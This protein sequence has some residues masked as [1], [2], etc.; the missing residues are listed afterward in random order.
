MI[1]DQ[2]LGVGLRQPLGL[3]A[4]SDSGREK[5]LRSPPTPQQRRAKQYAANGQRDR[6]AG[7]DHWSRRGATCRSRTSARNRNS[8]DSAA[9]ARADAHANC[10]LPK[11]SLPPSPEGSRQ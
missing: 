2:G 1:A 6:N 9:V 3:L 11:I 7:A 5:S 4:A 10:E 8:S